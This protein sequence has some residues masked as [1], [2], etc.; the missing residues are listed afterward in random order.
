[1]QEIDL[2]S[3]IKTNVLRLGA[4]TMEAFNDQLIVIE[5]EFRSGYE[6]TVC[7]GSATILCS[8]CAGRGYEVCDNC[9]GTGASTLVPGAKCTLC[10]GSGKL[11]CKECAGVKKRP[12]PSCAGRGVVEGGLVIP[13]A[14]ERRPTTGMIVSAGWKL[15]SAFA[16]FV[17]FFTGKQ[18][19]KR[20]DSVL[21][22]SF[23]GHV[24][25]LELPDGEV[26]VIRIL[27]DSDIKARVAGHLEL[28]RVKKSVAVD[29]AA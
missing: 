7:L 25:D 3:A 9:R 28:R 10:L 24:Y 5:D 14:S 21:Y 29:T 12:C 4:L 27:Q 15:N 26:I 1:M 13:E 2:K 19:L 8:T 22:T 20:G 17:A 23:S 16:R 11:T 18:L 6:C